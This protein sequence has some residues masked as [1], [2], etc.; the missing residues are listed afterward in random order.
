MPRHK[1]L[2]RARGEAD[3]GRLEG[4]LRGENALI[5]EAAAAGALRD[6]GRI[7]RA[8]VTD[9]E[10]CEAFER[11]GSRRAVGLELE[12]SRS[13]VSRR[14][15]A[16]G[17]PPGSETGPRVIVTQERFVEVYERV[18]AAG[19]MRKDIEMEL[20]MRGDT[21][22]SWADR[23]GLPPFWRT[24]APKVSDSALAEAARLG[25]TYTE[26]AERVGLKPGSLNG[27]LTKLGFSK[28]SR[29]ARITNEE[30]VAAL[31]TAGTNVGAARL[32]GVSKGMIIK[33]KRRMGLTRTHVSQA[34][35][36]ESYLKGGLIIEMAERVGLKY[37][38][39]AD[40]A[41]TLGLDTSKAR[42]LRINRRAME[43]I[44][45]WLPQEVERDMV[46]DA[47]NSRT[48]S[49]VRDLTALR[50]RLRYLYNNFGIWGPELAGYPSI[51]R[52]PLEGRIIP[53]LEY[54]VEMGGRREDISGNL[55]PI[56]LAADTMYVGF[57]RKRKMVGGF[58]DNESHVAAYRKFAA[59]MEEDLISEKRA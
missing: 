1:D 33:R 54:Y 10:L 58:A 8:R 37:D 55:F 24:R 29:Q 18:K 23:L 34:Q 57:L 2:A 30:V 15:K 19:G 12:M 42:Y 59:S 21:V 50:D 47:I 13:Q 45:T 11:L 43:L 46:M 51:L 35:I 56:L 36:E 38:A 14:L 41:R 17:V 9:E 53:R 4:M 3:N 48:A 5:P 39:F 6:G 52:Q 44:T 22:C 40:R 25:G 16:L 7:S 31:E 49:A 27:R 32:L 28:L 20:E 26:I